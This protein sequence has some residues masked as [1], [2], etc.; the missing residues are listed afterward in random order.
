MDQSEQLNYDRV[1]Y[2]IDNYNADKKNKGGAA[3]N[4]LNLEYHNN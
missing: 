1:Q 3:Y 2:K 4:I